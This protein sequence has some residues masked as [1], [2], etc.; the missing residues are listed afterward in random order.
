[1]PIHARDTEARADQ[2]RE[3]THEGECTTEQN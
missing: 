1:M 2:A 3:N